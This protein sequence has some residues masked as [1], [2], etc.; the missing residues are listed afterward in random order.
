MISLV[1]RV[2]SLGEKHGLQTVNRMIQ[3]RIK[4]A[5]GLTSWEPWLDQYIPIGPGIALDV[6]ANKGQWSRVL[7]ERFS[8]VYAFEPQPNVAVKLRKAM[9]EHVRVIAAAAWGSPGI[10]PLIEYGI[11]EL[12]VTATHDL[13]DTNGAAKGILFVPTVC[14]DWMDFEDVEFIKV[15]VEGAE[16]QV[17]EGAARTIEEQR[18]ILLI[19]NH[20]IE[21][22]E[23]LEEF[24]RR[25]QYDVQIISAP[26]YDRNDPASRIHVWLLG[27][28]R[29]VRHDTSTI[30]HTNGYKAK[31]PAAEAVR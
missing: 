3:W 7:A 6:G 20:S 4:A 15:D 8:Y 14:I 26:F 19:E 30:P 2:L 5:L 31:A 10:T 21:N 24:L 11:D 22:R 13:Q 29:K 12:S 9:P 16:M 27:T 1:N 23:R 18:P 25:L 17:I 28:P